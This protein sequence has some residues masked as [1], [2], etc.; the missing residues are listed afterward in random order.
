MLEE[1][2]MYKRSGIP[3]LAR[4]RQDLLLSYMLKLSLNPAW[5]DDTERR[6]GMRSHNK[7]KFKLPRTRNNG[8]YK[9]PLFRGVKLWDN[10]GSWYQTSKD[11]LTFKT[12]LCKIA[13]LTK[14]TENPEAR[15]PDMPVE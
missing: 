4:R 7:I 14:K 6:P 5:V 12:R 10:L 11:K 2:A 8:I 9:S 3:R 13:D 1:E 15:D